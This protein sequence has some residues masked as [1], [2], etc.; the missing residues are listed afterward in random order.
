MN[1]ETNISE[2]VVQRTQFIDGTMIKKKCFILFQES[3]F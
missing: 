1:N 3:N 2:I